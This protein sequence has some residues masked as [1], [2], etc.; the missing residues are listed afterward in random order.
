M[1]ETLTYQVFPLGD[2]AITIDFGN[3]IDGAVND[4]VIDLFKKLQ[5]NPLPGMIEMVPAFS[6]L[7][8]YYD[9]ALIRKKK[10]SGNTAF[11]Q[12]KDLL[13]EL[14]TLPFTNE[15]QT[16][17]LM[18]IP[19][20][21]EKE[22]APDMEEMCV[23]SGLTAEEIITIHTGRQYRVFMLGFLPGFAYMGPVDD[24]I[25]MPRKTRPRSIAAGSVGIAGLQTGIYPLA[26][27]GG[28]QIIGRT[29]LQLFNKK[30]EECTLLKAG[31]RVEFYSIS[32]EEFGDI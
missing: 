16:A 27:P 21:Y 13:E 29:P 10:T 18:R 22:M 30:E 14:I 11:E 5:K 26:S 24:R 25:N 12:I 20:C 19:V 23:Y 9:I 4:R 7:T 28:W 17:R 2:S 6:S 15:Q 32:R 8:L 3:R 31:D 1:Q